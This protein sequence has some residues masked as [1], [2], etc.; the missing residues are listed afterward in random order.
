MKSYLKALEIEPND[1]G[2][3]LS[4]ARVY[5]VLENY[6]EEI[7]IYKTLLKNSNNNLTENSLKY[8]INLGNA[9]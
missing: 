2:V 8:L 3:L 6:Q 4:L 7:N 1:V 5:S 9:L